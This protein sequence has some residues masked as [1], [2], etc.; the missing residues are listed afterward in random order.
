MDGVEPAGDDALTLPSSLVFVDLETTGAL[1]G[2][3]RIMEI[4]IVR[5][6]AGEVIEEWSSLVDPERPIPEF[7]ARFTGISQS[8]VD[9]AP[10]FAQL[11]PTV[12]EKLGGA[13]FVAHNARFDYGFLRAEFLRLGVQ[14]S[15]DVLCT[16]RLSR[17]L[18]P[19]H[20]RHNLDAVMARH[21]LTCRARHRALGDAQVLSDLWLHLNAGVSRPRLAAAARAALVVTPVLPAN[22]PPGLADEIPES[23]GVYRLRGATGEV[24]YVGRAANLRTRLLAQLAEPAGVRDRNLAALVHGIDWFE[25]GGE[26]GALLAESAW[27]ESTPPQYRRQAT[28]DAAVTL[29]LSADGRPAIL[30]LAEVGHHERSAA[31]GIFHTAKDARK[32]LVDI[33]R[34]HALCLKAMGLESGVGACLAHAQGRCR[35]AC[36]GTEAP[37]KHGLRVQLALAAL[38]LRQWPFPGRIGLRERDRMHVLEQWRYLGTARTEPELYELAQQP[39]PDGFDANAYRILSRYVARHPDIDWRDLR[40]V[41]A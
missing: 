12:L 11:A 9:G 40:P 5:M 7:I 27:C 3:D 29:L 13:V 28:Q 16:V 22:L 14:F 31:C 2:R 1:S 37:L 34:A 8:M 38:K 26:L 30:P 35:G 24:L 33:A 15:A 6:H 39:L 18:F 17:R 10:R 4:G 25:T 20:P 19:E 21:G 32:A 23:T 36:L 41:A